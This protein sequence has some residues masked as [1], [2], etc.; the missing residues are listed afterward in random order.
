MTFLRNPC[1]YVNPATGRKCLSRMTSEKLHG[2]CRA[3]AIIK[4]VVASNQN[5]TSRK[6][7]L[8]RSRQEEAK[9]VHQERA[10]LTA[11]KVYHK[12]IGDQFFD[13]VEMMREMEQTGK[14]IS[15]RMAKQLFIR[16]WFSDPVTRR[17]ANLEYVA[18]ALNWKKF[19]LV[20]LI[21]SDEF[22]QMIESYK[23]KIDVMI[24]PHIQRV[25]LIKG[26][27]G[28]R[29]ALKAYYGQVDDSIKGVGQFDWND[30]DKDLLDEARN[31]S[32]VDNTQ[33]G[34]IHLNDDE[35]IMAGQI[36]EEI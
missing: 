15:E 10:K 29:D 33:T 23:K 12:I 13:L 24:A 36:G 19:R 14:T 25:L 7:S 32:G 3:H 22:N 27:D 11:D 5:E 34:M 20:E 1:K 6:I 28:D 35:H 18:H 17:P 2:Y 4:G 30:V 26:L 8:T 16:W 9:K 21:D 31:L